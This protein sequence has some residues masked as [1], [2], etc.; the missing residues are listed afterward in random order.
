MRPDVFRAAM[1]DVSRVLESL[2]RELVEPLGP[3][4]AAGLAPSGPGQDPAHT[5]A[6]HRRS[7]IKA[8]SRD[9]SG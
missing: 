6:A 4:P 8:Q 5:D 2:G 7:A 3:G 9:N 1:A